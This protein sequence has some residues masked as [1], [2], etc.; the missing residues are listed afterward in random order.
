M[1]SLDKIERG[2]RR[3]TISGVPEGYDGR[4]LADLALGGRSVL[5]VARDDRRIAQLAATLAFWG[6][7]IEVLPL[8]AW[9]CL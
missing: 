2:T 6:E 5:F 1:I 4:V 3:A 7:G 9:D 8:P